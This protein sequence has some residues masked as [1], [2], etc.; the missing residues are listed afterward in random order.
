M[1]CL[2]FYVVFS[3]NIK[4]MT[5]TNPYE[6]ILSWSNIDLYS[7]RLFA[8]SRI[9][10]RFGLELISQSQIYAFWKPATLENSDSLS[11]RISIRNLSNNESD[12]TIV[13][14]PCHVFDNLKQNTLYNIRVTSVKMENN[15]SEESEAADISITTP[16]DGISNNIS[17]I[18]IW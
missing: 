8:D 1:G 6:W 17:N 13:T 3:N 15:N 12:D 10:R 11:Y 18:L 5:T 2:F 14:Y 4:S 9:P 16:Q 7:N